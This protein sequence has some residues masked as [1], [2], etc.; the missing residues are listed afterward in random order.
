[1]MM[2]VCHFL[3]KLTDEGSKSFDSIQILKRKKT[4][5]KERRPNLHTKRNMRNAT[6]SL[7][8]FHNIIDDLT[9]H[10]RE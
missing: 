1:M 9:S 7:V 2:G 5:K 3:C 6:T 4:T 10:H 8:F